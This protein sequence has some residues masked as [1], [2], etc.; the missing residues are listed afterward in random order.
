M[1]C[2]LTD[3]T[4]SD[5]RYSDQ[6]GITGI[7]FVLPS[8][9]KKRTKYTKQR[10]TRH[11]TH[12]EMKASGPWETRSKPDEPG[13]PTYILEWLGLRARRRIEPS[14]LIGSGKRAENRLTGQ[15]TGEVR[16]TQSENS[17]DLQRVL[18]EYLAEQRY[19]HIHVS[20]LCGACPKTFF[21]ANHCYQMIFLLSSTAIK[22]V[23]QE[24]SKGQEKTGSQL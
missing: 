20:K 12:Q 18:L 17:R 15:R 2:W 19:Q 6:D 5:H 14:H 21:F 22:K 13:C 10:F 3:Y 1:R 16:L 9:P 24:T 4:S 7:R 11:Y 8:E 23:K